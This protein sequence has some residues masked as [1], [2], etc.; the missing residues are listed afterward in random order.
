MHLFCGSLFIV[1]VFA[2]FW[3]ALNRNR[4]NVSLPLWGRYRL[5]VM[6]WCGNMV[7]GLIINWR[8]PMLRLNA[9]TVI[10]RSGYERETTMWLQ[11]PLNQEYDLRPERRRW[12]WR[13]FVDFHSTHLILWFARRAEALGMETIDSEDG[14]YNSWSGE[15][16]WRFMGII[17]THVY[18]HGSDLAGG[19]T[20]YSLRLGPI[21]TWT[22]H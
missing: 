12:R 2:M 7:D 8:G 9:I 16:R 10:L 14:Y 13:G 20:V 11:L 4:I 6:P 15:W 1:V 3:L 21:Q 5:M 22:L 19:S 18:F 17:P